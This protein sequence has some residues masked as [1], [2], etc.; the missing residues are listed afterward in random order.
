MIF[1]GWHVNRS[2]IYKYVTSTSKEQRFIRNKRNFWSD[3]NFAVWCSISDRADWNH[4]LLPS[5]PRHIPFL[6]VSTPISPI[7]ATFLPPSTL[8]AFHLFCS[9]P[10]PTLTSSS[11]STGFHLAL[12]P[13]LQL[14]C[15]PF[16]PSLLLTSEHQPCLD[17]A[18]IT[19]RRCHRWRS[20]CAGTFRLYVSPKSVCRHLSAHDPIVSATSTS[21]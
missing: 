21:G 20:R 15:S 13:Q 16:R 11:L 7:P 5:T 9:I 17:A 12:F 4:L 10:S 19:G 1:D 18:Y 3:S 6:S 8:S 14:R 2:C